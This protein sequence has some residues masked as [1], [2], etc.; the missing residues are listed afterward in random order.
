MLGIGLKMTSVLVFLTMASFLKVN[1]EIPLGELVFFRSFFAIP[2]ILVFLAVRGELISGV[3]TSR[4]FG[5]LRRGLTGVMGMFCGFYGIT[6]LPLPETTVIGYT[7]P[8]LIV[9]LSAVVLK[10]TVRLYRWTAVLLGLVGVAIIVAPRLTV[11]SGGVDALGGSGLGALASLGGAFFA[12]LA[13][14]AIKD[15]TKSERSATI[16]FYFS[17]TCTAFSLLTLPLGWV[18]PTPEQA[19]TLILAGTCGGIAQVLLT[20]CFRY[21]DM[22]VIAPFEYTSLI[23]SI[24][25]G[26]WIFGD[27]VTWQTLAGSLIVVGSGLFIIL[28]ERTLGIRNARIRDQVARPGGG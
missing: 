3:K 5:H 4:P 2:P 6:Q 21:A 9:I 10:E 7:S 16:A 20:E 25:I 12:S 24:I 27:I 18:V 15:L 11:L 26:W 17:L 13:S 1:E 8:L 28:R 19:L 14:L 23:F 22:S